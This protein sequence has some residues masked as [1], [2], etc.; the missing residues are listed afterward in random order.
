MNCSIECIQK[1]TCI[2]S[3]AASKLTT[4]Y[5]TELKT[6]GQMEHVHHFIY[7]RAQ[8]QQF[9]PNLNK[10]YRYLFQYFRCLS[11]TVI[12]WWSAILSLR[13]Q[14]KPQKKITVG[15]SHVKYLIPSVISNDMALLKTDKKVWWHIWRVEIKLLHHARM[16]VISDDSVQ[17]A[18]NEYVHFSV[19]TFLPMNKRS[20]VR[21]SY[22]SETW[23][24]IVVPTCTTHFLPKRWKYTISIID[25]VGRI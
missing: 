23:P 17:A 11:T 15:C 14:F 10:V 2:H 1:I 22:V 7:L 21:K 6:K 24:T 18:C 16:M 12:T 3:E 13:G 19:V 9:R 25:I 4:V 20:S 8:N 5:F